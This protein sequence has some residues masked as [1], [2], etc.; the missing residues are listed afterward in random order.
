MARRTARG[1]VTLLDSDILAV[2]C[3][4]RNLA[5]NAV[6]GARVLLND[7]LEGLERERYTL[8]A[9]NP[10][11][12]S[13]QEVNSATTE[14][15]LKLAYARLEPRGRLVIV[16]NRFLPYERVL[17]AVFGSSEVLYEDTRF[18]VLQAVK[19]YRKRGQAEPDAAA[20]EWDDDAENEAIRSAGPKRKGG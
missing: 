4:E 9:S 18:R 7:G 2:D 6:S 20:D 3:A 1:S 5:A 13:G 10:P 16:A 8:I 12:H 14:R 17:N 11:F 15:W 19:V